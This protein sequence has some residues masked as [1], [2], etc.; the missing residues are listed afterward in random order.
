[1]KRVDDSKNWKT[2]ILGIGVFVFEF[3]LFF[4]FLNGWLHLLFLLIFQVALVGFLVRYVYHCFKR[5]EDLRYP[6]LLLV[7]V[8]GAGPF[9]AAGFLLL[10]LLYPLF[11]KFSTPPSVWFEDLFPEEKTL[12]F[13]RIYQRVKSGWDDYSQPNEVDSFQDLFN[14]GALSQKQAVLDAIVKDF[15][16]SYAPILKQALNDPQNTVRIQA[17][18]IVAKIDDEFAMEQTKLH[19]EEEEKPEKPEIILKLA[20]HFDIYV[21]LGLQDILT[22]KRLT[23]KAIEYYQKYLQIKPNDLR[24]WLAIGKLLFNQ[25]DYENFLIWC[26]N[27]RKKYKDLPRLVQS[28]YLE[29]LYRLHRYEEL[30]EHVGGL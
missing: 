22:S 19:E 17:A 16:P 18:A 10:T 27:Y 3:I 25:K 26:E 23:E 24:V 7:S 20:E 21:S 29:A 5:R 4:I 14:H 6:L 1:M 28:W 30:A 15:N 12:L 2:T 11:K 13:G 9:G 8:F